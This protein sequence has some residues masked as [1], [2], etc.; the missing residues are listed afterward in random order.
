MNRVYRVS[1]EVDLSAVEKVD[2]EPEGESVIFHLEV[3]SDSAACAVISALSC[4]ADDTCVMAVV[5]V[6]EG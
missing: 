1:L 4:L 5:P 6:R 2:Y 3:T